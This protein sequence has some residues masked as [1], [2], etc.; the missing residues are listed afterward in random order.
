MPRAL[1]LILTFIHTYRYI[2]IHTHTHARMHA[3]TRACMHACIRARIHTLALASTPAS[4]HTHAD[5][6]L[7]HASMH[8]YRWAVSLVLSRSFEVNL[9]DEKAL[10]IIP[11]VDM[12]NHKSFPAHSSSVTFD[13]EANE[14]VVHA[15]EA[16]DAGA[17]VGV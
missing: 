4:Q 13:N 1:V 10:V 12:L 16:S 11:V 2:D 7:M 14:L 8:T 5:A 6:G 17:E 9:S 3:Y 15:R